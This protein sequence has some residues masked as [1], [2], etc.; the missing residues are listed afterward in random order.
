MGSGPHPPSK[1]GR[2]WL[3][4]PGEH[5]GADSRVLAGSLVEENPGSAILAGQAQPL[6]PD[7]SRDASAT[8]NSR[9]TPN[10]VRV[11]PLL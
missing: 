6:P 4:L 10:A 2:P 3:D 9:G 5:G 7:T 1:N 8:R 11:E